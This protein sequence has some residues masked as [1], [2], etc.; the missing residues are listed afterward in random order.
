MWP[1]TTILVSLIEGDDS[2]LALCCSFAV[3]SQGRITVNVDADQDFS[4]LDREK[5]DTLFLQYEA[6]DGGGLRES[7]EL[8]VSN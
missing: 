8:Q 5:L 1:E 2:H 4:L 7:V 3:D 6:I